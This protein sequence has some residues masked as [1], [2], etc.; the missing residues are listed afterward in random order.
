MEVKGRRVFAKFR[1]DCTGFDDYSI[2]INPAKTRANFEGLPPSLPL[3]STYA[4]AGSE[5]IK[6]CG[7]LI[8][9]RTLVRRLHL[10][11]RVLP[12]SNML[13]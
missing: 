10:A 1:L 12:T 9:C 2:R 8:N 11:N 7:L 13:V 6:W 5:F 3:R 4:V